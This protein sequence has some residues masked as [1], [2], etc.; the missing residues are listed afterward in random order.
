MMRYKRFIFLFL[1]GFAIYSCQDKQKLETIIIE[2]P[3]LEIPIAA[4]TAKTICAQMDSIYLSMFY[5]DQDYRNGLI[6]ENMDSIN[7]KLFNTIIARCDFPYDKD[8]KDFRSYLGRCTVLQHSDLPTIN[9]YIDDFK[10][11]VELGKLSRDFLALLKDRQVLLLDLPQLYGNQ[12]QNGKLNPVAAI[13]E[14]RARRQSMNFTES[15]D[16]YLERQGLDWEQE[17]ERLQRLER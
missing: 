13:E 5:R 10:Q 7:L 9:S 4:D 2:S 17:Y 1:L 11:L 6:D 16:Q 8:F 12:I 14:S 3:Q 15:M